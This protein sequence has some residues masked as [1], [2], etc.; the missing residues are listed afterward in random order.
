MEELWSALI[1]LWRENAGCPII[2]GHYDVGIFWYR[3]PVQNQ[4]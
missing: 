1:F 2:V 4:K 3:Q